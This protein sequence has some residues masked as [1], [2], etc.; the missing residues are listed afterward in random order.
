MA[1]HQVAN[2]TQPHMVLSLENASDGSVP[3]AENVRTEDLMKKEL[4]RKR[5]PRPG[6]HSSGG[7]PLT[8]VLLELV[9]KPGIGSIVAKSIRAAVKAGLGQTAH[10]AGS[11][12]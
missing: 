11:P 8:V 2:M 4:R 3:R 5:T 12:N 7:W 1:L 6:S 10:F 9:A